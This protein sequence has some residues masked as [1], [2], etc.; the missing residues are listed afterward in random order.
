[1]AFDENSQITDHY[2]QATALY[3]SVYQNKPR[4]F[5]LTQAQMT[6]VQEL[7]DAIW[8][9]ITLRLI[10]NATK[11]QL[12]VLGKLVGQSRIEADDDTYRR[13]IQ[14]RIRANRSIGKVNDIIEVAQAFSPNSGYRY[15]DFYPASILLEQFALS[16]SGSLDADLAAILKGFI[17]DAKPAGVD[18]SLH[19]TEDLESETFE[20]SSTS[21]PEDDTDKGWGDEYPTSGDGGAWIGTV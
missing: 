12:D 1:M 18:I 15:Y 5:G 9:V 10:D 7:S 11:G 4:L 16:M 6:Q 2:E 3:T 8:D 20:F 17:E 13:R 14:T 21:D 19:F